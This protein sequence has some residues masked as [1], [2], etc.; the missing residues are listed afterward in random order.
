MSV[1]S[2]LA[3]RNQCCELVMPVPVSPIATQIIAPPQPF[4]RPYPQLY[5][6][7]YSTNPSSVDPPIYPAMYRNQQ[8]LHQMSLPPNSFPQS[9]IPLNSQEDDKDYHRPPSYPIVEY[10]NDITLLSGNI[11]INTTDSIPE[12]YLI[13]DGADISRSMYPDL[14]KAIGT[15]YG[16]GD[17]K[18]TFSLPNL[19]DDNN[20]TH[21]LIKI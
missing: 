16:V 13:C 8:S 2:R 5:P 3:R 1:K 15:Y 10:S 4:H 20:T 14:F 9:V 18:T 6:P 17:K 12:G 7:G 19:Q 21:Y 11:V